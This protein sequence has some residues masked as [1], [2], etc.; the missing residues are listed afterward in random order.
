MRPKL[1]GVEISTVGGSELKDLGSIRG[2]QMVKISDSMEVPL[3]K[4]LEMVEFSILY[5][6][7]YRWIYGGYIQ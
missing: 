6:L 3:F 2:I 1:R 4:P 5:I 7:Q